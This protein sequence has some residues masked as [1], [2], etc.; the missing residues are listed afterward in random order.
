MDYTTASLQGAVH[1]S[2]PPYNSTAKQLFKRTLLPN[3]PT[4][5][6]VV[7]TT[8][9]NTQPA[10]AFRCF[11]SPPVAFIRDQRELGQQP[12]EQRTSLISRPAKT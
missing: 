7:L 8:S 1:Y 6:T 4:F 2:W 9:A 3:T 5:V 10:P 12:E 11:M